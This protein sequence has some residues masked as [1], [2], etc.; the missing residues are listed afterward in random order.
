VIAISMREL[1]LDG[2]LVQSG[3]DVARD[4]TGREGLSAS[5][6]APELGAV[7]WENP[8]YGL[9]GGAA[10]NV[11]YGGTGILHCNRKSGVVMNLH[12]R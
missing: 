8:T 11:D 2:R 12:I 1:N 6:K 5:W 10:G 3:L 4:D 7:P 9:S